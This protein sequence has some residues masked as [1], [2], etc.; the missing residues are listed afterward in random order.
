MIMMMMMM[1][2]VTLAAAPLPKKSIA[3]TT[4][5]LWLTIRASQPELRNSQLSYL[6]IN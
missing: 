1:T 4:K 3:H 6:A 5:K 2:T